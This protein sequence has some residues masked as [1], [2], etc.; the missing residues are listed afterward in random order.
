MNEGDISCLP[1]SSTAAYAR[2]RSDGGYQVVIMKH[3]TTDWKSKV[4][5]IPGNA[6]PGP[7]LLSSTWNSGNFGLPIGLHNVAGTLLDAQTRLGGVASP[8]PPGPGIP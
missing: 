8:A 5:G 2:W 4:F 7:R 1:S 3:G 6:R